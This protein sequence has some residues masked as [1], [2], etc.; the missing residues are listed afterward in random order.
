MIELA[1]AY[2]D[3]PDV[4]FLMVSVDKD[5]ER[6]KKYALQTN[7]HQYGMDVIIPDGMNGE[8]GNKYL[9]KAIPK[10][11]LIDKDGI[12]IDPNL[13]EPSLNMKQ[14]IERAEKKSQPATAK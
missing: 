14:R 10:Y 11:I 13:S 9:V 5:V 7:N 3:V 2:Q 4:V 12:I 1:K 6:W 8:F